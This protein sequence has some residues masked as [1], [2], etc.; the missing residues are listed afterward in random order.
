M[1]PGD[2]KSQNS[3]YGSFCH[4]PCDMGGAAQTARPVGPEGG[5]SGGDG[6]GGREAGGGGTNR[7]DGDDEQ[8]GAAGQSNAH[9]ESV[10]VNF[11]TSFGV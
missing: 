9:D 2:S 6:G 5:G 8:G 4:T 1:L 10:T 3:D 11:A 7:S